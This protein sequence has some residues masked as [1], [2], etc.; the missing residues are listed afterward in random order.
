MM[1]TEEFLSQDAG[2]RGLNDVVSVACRAQHHPDV[3]VDL[4]ATSRLRLRRRV[5][6]GGVAGLPDE[7]LLELIVQRAIP[8]QD[9]K[10][11]IHRLLS[12][13]GDLACVMAA[14]ESRLIELPGMTRS[15]VDHLK[16]MEMTGHRMARAS[17]MNRVVL[18]NWDALMTYLHTA[19]SHLETERFRVLYL[20]KRNVLVA[21]EELGSGTVDHVPVYPREVVRRALAFNASAL[22]VVH[23]H[24]SGYAMPSDAD[25]EMTRR[26]ETAAAALDLVLHDHVIIGRGEDFSFREQGLI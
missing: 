22:I 25:I 14:P 9:V 10:P 23:N 2:G 21:D 19:L 3:S 26:L 1:D 15:L 13:F 20:D 12:V 11:L 8:R 18:D 7:E 4:A 24:P 5:R 17:V 16:V 6:N